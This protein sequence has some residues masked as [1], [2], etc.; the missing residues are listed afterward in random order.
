MGWTIS[1]IWLS[2]ISWISQMWLCFAP[3]R[4]S[5]ACRLRL[6][7]RARR[8]CWSAQIGRPRSRVGRAPVPPHDAVP[9]TDSEE[10]PFASR[11]HRHR[12]SRF[13]VRLGLVRWLR[14]LRRV[15][16]YSTERHRPLRRCPC[17]GRVD[18]RQPALRVDLTL[19][20]GVI[21]IATAGLD[22]AVRVAV[23]K[24]SDMIATRVAD[25]PFTLIASPGY[26][27]RFGQPAT[28]EDLVS[29]PCY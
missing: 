3:L 11:S 6:V 26:V 25:N 8:R 14:P 1:N 17:R 4:P 21:D 15:E 18:R 13:G 29:H 9:I 19:S 7:R 22:V 5:A 23:L 27:A 10:R 28:T 16:D 12:S 24:P 2:V 20:D